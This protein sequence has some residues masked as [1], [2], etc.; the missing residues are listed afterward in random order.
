MQTNYSIYYPVS[1][2][3]S[4]DLVKYKKIM[5]CTEPL[6]HKFNLYRK[7]NNKINNI[8]SKPTI[9]KKI[10]KVIETRLSKNSSKKNLFNN[11]KRHYNDGLK[12][13]RYNYE[14]NYTKKC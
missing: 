9:L 11:I 7:N 4:S 1:V 5:N 2:G 14:I 6:N 12:I 10:S 8:N 13:N 3:K